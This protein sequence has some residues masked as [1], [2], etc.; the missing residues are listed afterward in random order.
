MYKSLQTVGLLARRGL[1]S[2][3][4]GLVFP[5]FA[6]ERDGDLVAEGLQ[7]AALLLRAA[8]VA[9]WPGGRTP[10][11]DYCSGLDVRHLS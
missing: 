7:G 5:V 4:H 3:V 10:A 11:H 1:C 8:A 6:A 2:P 9:L